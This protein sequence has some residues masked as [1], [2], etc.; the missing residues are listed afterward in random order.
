MNVCSWTWTWTWTA[1]CIS[2]SS[3][4]GLW[5][6]LLWSCCG[7]RTQRPCCVALPG[8]QRWMA[9][10]EGGLKVLRGNRR[11]PACAAT[12]RPSVRIWFQ[13]SLRLQLTFN[14]S[15]SLS[16]LHHRSRSQGQGPTPPSQGVAPEVT[17]AN[18]MLRRHA[19][20]GNHAN[21]L[22]TIPTCQHANHSNM[23]KC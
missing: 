3:C 11:R 19:N 9:V 14:A 20:H 8:S 10:S 17:H 16:V 15:P 2:S 12:S 22:T 7:R 23:L 18:N 6:R 1:S 13:I 4:L 21:M 5:L